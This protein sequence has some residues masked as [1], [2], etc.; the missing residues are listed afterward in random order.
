MGGTAVVVFDP[1]GSNQPHLAKELQQA[2]FDVREKFD[3]VEPES[4][5]IDLPRVVLRTSA[6]NHIDVAEQAKLSPGPTYWVFPID[7]FLQEAGATE[8]CTAEIGS[9]L[10]EMLDRLVTELSPLETLPEAARWFHEKGAICLGVRS[11]ECHFSSLAEDPG[12]SA[13]PMPAVVGGLARE[14]WARQPRPR[15]LIGI[16]ERPL[17]TNGELGADQQASPFRYWIWVP[18]EQGE[19]LIGHLLIQPKEEDRPSCLALPTVLRWVAVFLGRLDPGS[20]DPRGPGNR[21]MSALR[22]KEASSRE[23]TLPKSRLLDAF[24]MGVAVF[25]NNKEI[26]ST[27]QAFRDLSPLS[28]PNEKK[29]DIADWPSLAGFALRW[30]DWER[31]LNEALK[32]RRIANLGVWDSEE[33]RAT[34]RSLL[35]SVF[36]VVNE[37]DEC[38]GGMIVV[39]PR[40]TTRRFLRANFP[41]EMRPRMEDL[42]FVVSH[43]LSN[44]LDGSMRFLNLALGE[45][46]PESKEAPYL[47]EVKAGLLRI[48][49]VCKGLRQ[50]GIKFPAAQGQWPLRVNHAIEQAVDRYRAQ[51]DIIGAKIQLDLSPEDPIVDGTNLVRVFCSLIV[52]SL[53][54]LSGPGEITISSEAKEGMAMVLFHDTGPG[55]EETLRGKIFNAFTSYWRSGHGLGLGLPLARRQIKSMGGTLSLRKDSRV[56]ACFEICLP[57]HADSQR[58]EECREPDRRGREDGRSGLLPHD[59]SVKDVVGSPAGRGNRGNRR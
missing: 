35:I 40:R 20:V 41:L 2:G 17:G 39:Q 37:D 47:N 6:S 46:D 32:K 57:L 14:V 3:A 10:I 36:P 4:P 8:P 28:G 43:E 44:P 22:G 7:G 18:L 25:N 19:E 58:P 59:L 31:V 27:N 15:P 34:G 45:I 1:A 13:P 38:V 30:E 11:I 53:E 24:P 55:V 49:Y 5:P 23:G 50:L 51:A 52:N 26:I 54:S 48:N 21:L 33:G 9:R 42:V 29:L 12:M 56:G 16:L